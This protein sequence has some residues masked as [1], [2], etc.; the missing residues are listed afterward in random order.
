MQKNYICLVDLIN[1]SGT[2]NLEFKFT[3]TKFERVEF[4]Y[5]NVLKGNELDN[6]SKLICYHR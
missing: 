2:I 3:R 4:I 5:C 1:E 6:K